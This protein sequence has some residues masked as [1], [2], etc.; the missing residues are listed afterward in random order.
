MCVSMLYEAPAHRHVYSTLH[1]AATLNHEVL[2]ERSAHAHMCIAGSTYVRVL[3]AD[4]VSNISNTIY[5]N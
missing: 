3:V 1:E 2:H 5:Y 4:V